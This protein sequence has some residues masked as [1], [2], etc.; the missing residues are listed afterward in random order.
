MSKL[1][2]PHED[3][4][5]VF[6]RR[7]ASSYAVEAERMLDAAIRADRLALLDYIEASYIIPPIRLRDLR[8][9]IAGE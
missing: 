2:T 4:L 8:R 7:V 5:R 6:L 1:T 3:A 9:E